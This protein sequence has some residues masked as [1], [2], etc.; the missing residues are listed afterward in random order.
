[1]F[2]DVPYDRYMTEV[3]RGLAGSG[4]FLTAKGEKLNTMTIGWGF[5][6]RM[7]AMPI[8]IVPVR[9]SRFTY[10]LI[11][12]SGEFTVSVPFSSLKKELALCGAKSGRDIDKFKECGLTPVSGKVV[13]VPVIEQCDLHFECKV[14][15]KK[16]VDSNSLNQ[17]YDTRCYPN[18][19]YHT[20][21]FGEIVACY[22]KD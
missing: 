7:W 12:K 5:V 16:D 20:L 22:M 4:I 14:V 1:M 11:E 19:D 17:E 18:G 2:K 13:D 3:N 8:F 21:F 10:G 6:G 9:K 15:F